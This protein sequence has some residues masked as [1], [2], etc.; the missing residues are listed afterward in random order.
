MAVS[1]KKIIALCTSRIYD[2]Q[3][4]GYI[5]KLNERLRGENCALLIYTINSDLYWKDENIT[6]ETKVFDIVPYNLADVVIIMDEKIKHQKITNGIIDKAKEYNVPTIIVDGYYD[7]LPHINFDYGAGFEQVVRHVL[8]QRVVH[9]PHLMAGIPGNPFSDERIDIFK[10]VIAE[11]GYTYDEKSMLSYGQFW[12]GPAREAIEKIV[13]SGDIPDAIICANDIMAIN[14][15][16]VLLN[17]GIAIPEDVMVSGYDGYDE[18]FVTD[19]KITTVS[20]TTPELA[21]ATADMVLEIVSD[22]GSVS[23]IDLQNGTMVIP[24]LITNESTGSTSNTG[25][26]RSMLNRF[27]NSFYRHQDAV[28]VMY[29]IASSMQMSHSPEEMISHLNRMIVN[30]QNVITDVAL[31]INRNIFNTDEYFF[32]NA[33][34]EVDLTDYTL[35]YDANMSPELTEIVADGIHVVYDYDEFWKKTKEGFPLIFN[36]IDYMN[37]PLGFVCYEYT[38]YDITKYSRTANITNT[39]S[40]GI[41]SYVNMAYQRT[42]AEKIDRMYKKDSLTGLYNRVGFN[43]VY[44]ELRGTEAFQGED[45]TVIMSD[46]DGLKY[47]NDNFGHAEGDNAIATAAM[48]L[49]KACPE[50]AT[51]VRFG[52]D[53]LF[54]LIIGD[55]DTEEIKKKIE[56][57]LKEYNQTSGKEYSVVA[58]CGFNTSEFN[59]SFDIKKALK[60]ADEQMYDI[61]KEHKKSSWYSSL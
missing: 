36:T 29:E 12:A 1:G 17:H 25:F 32:D 22:P 43:M 48:A 35:I 10:K 40:M 38:T 24:T 16:D 23:D 58:S 21:D 14:V 2:S 30:D 42:L 20:C 44:E 50:K 3:V 52:G 6:A 34:K 33:K 8:D 26:N 46:L 59:E 31:C 60:R 41:G 45:I 28:R 5:E 27:N 19:P 39:I 15:C 49:Q 9:K 13:E 18:V 7:G 56:Q 53:E 37:A 54:A 11:Y 51:C 61:K 57:F 55:C 4:H 47:I